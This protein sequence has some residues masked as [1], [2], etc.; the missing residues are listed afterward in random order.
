M[1]CFSLF[2]CVVCTASFFTISPV[3][4][5]APLPNEMP[6]TPITKAFLH[7]YEDN[8]MEV[9]LGAMLVS[10]HAGFRQ[11]KPLVQALEQGRSHAESI[12]E[13]TFRNYALAL[14]QGNNNDADNLRF[15]NEFPDKPKE[16]MELFS[17]EERFKAPPFSYL[18]ELLLAYAYTGGTAPYYI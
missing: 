14:L 5:R 18:L 9:R 8:E 6:P 16:L 3:K 17:F 4:A 7:L 13:A 1:K 15:V 12:T 10:G 11:W 2:L